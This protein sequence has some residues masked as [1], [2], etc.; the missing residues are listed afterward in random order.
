MNKQNGWVTLH[1]KL[2]ENP[3]SC[4]SDYLSIWVHLLLMAN[5]EPTTFIWNNK[6][7]T[8]NA[9]QLLTGRKQLSKKTGIAESQVYKILKYLETE[10]QIE[11]Q[12]TTKYTVITITNWHRYQDKE[13][14]KEQQSNNRVTTEEQQSNTYNNVNNDNNENKKEYNHFETFWKTYPRKIGK[15]KCEQKYN[16]LATS[17]ERETQIMKGLEIYCNKWRVEKTNLEYIP[18]PYTWLNQERFL[19]EVTIN[20]EV[21]NSFAREN[22][23]KWE[24]KKQEEKQLY[25]EDQRGEMVSISD[26]VKKMDTRGVVGA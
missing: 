25:V 9:G 1:R 24:Q 18:H 6:K 26:I 19:D 12:K 21:F 3:I 7:Q 14:Q 10:Q 2:L 13:Q 4:K 22:E 17:K 8:L 23:K 20:R 11:Q 5:H 16:L 15:K